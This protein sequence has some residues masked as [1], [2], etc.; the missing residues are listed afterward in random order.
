MAAFWRAPAGL[1]LASAQLPDEGELPS[2]D[3]ATGWLN[4]ESLTP[5]ELRGKVVLIDFWTYTCINWLRQLPYVRAWA[6][7]YS[8]HGLVVIGVHTPEFSFEHNADNVRR[9]VRE[10]RITYPVATDNNYGVWLAFDNHYW[11]AL[12]FADAQGRI[13]HHHFGEGEYAQSEMVLQQLLAEAGAAGAGTDM[14]SVDPSGLEVP[15]NWASLRSP[16]NY[17][18]Y[19]RTEGF[20]SPGGAVPGKPHAY[21]VPAHLGLNE[22][23]LSGDWTMAEETS[24]VNAANGRIV[25][26]FHA[27]DLNLVMGPVASGGPVRCRVRIDGQPPGEA[28]GTDVDSEGNGLVTY[29]RVYQLIR[30]PGSITDRTFEITFPD[31]GLQAFCFTFG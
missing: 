28:A 15:A 21:T 19:E 16:E 27:R 2:F 25:C 11:P 23:A 10:M 31:A 4:S 29:Q 20:A 14:V 3:G 22:W 24:T 7:K 26:R 12:Y 13:R 17:T 8:G 6:E 1:H 18:G 5:A 30:Q 9:A